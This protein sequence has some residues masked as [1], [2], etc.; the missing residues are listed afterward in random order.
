MDPIIEAALNAY[1]QGWSPI[2][3]VKGEKRPAHSDWQNTKYKSRDEIE[4]AFE[5]RNVGLLVGSAS[6]NLIDIDL[7]SDEAS[8]LASSFLPS[9]RMIHGRET[10][11]QSH[12]WYQCDDKVKYKKFTDPTDD[13]A[14]L[15]IRAKG[16]TVIPPSSHPSGEDYEW[17]EG[18][19]PPAQVPANTL[20]LDCHLLAAASLLAKHWPGEGSRHDASLALAGG[21]IAYSPDMPESRQTEDWVHD[22]CLLVMGAAGDEECIERADL[23]VPSTYKLH[24]KNKKVKGWKSLSKLISPKVLK[25]VRDWISYQ[26][27]NADLFEEEVR[28]SRTDMS[29]FISLDA[30]EVVEIVNGVIY[31]GKV[32]WLQGEP[33]TGKTIYALYLVKLC[34]DNG[35]RVMFVDEESGAAMTGKRLAALG[36]TPEDAERGFFYYQHTGIN[37]MDFEYRELFAEEVRQYHPDLIIFDSVADLMAQADLEENSNDHVN[38]FIKGFV[39]TVRRE[40]IATLFIDHLAKVSE[41]GQWARGAGSKKA[42]TDVAWTFSAIKS[43]NQNLMGDVSLKNAKDRFG[44]MPASHRYDIGG[45]GDGLIHITAKST[46]KEYASPSDKYVKKVVDYLKKHHSTDQNPIPTTELGKTIPGKTSYIRTAIKWCRDNTESL[47]IDFLKD[48]NTTLWYYSGDMELDFSLT[49]QEEK[50]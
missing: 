8:T 42:K 24:K 3:I 36:V 27:E 23:D 29:Q 21:L 17:W 10:S 43:F 6:N 25:V 20:V 9:T 48:G 47:P 16:Q 32:H 37:V 7:D 34:L 45:N 28:F 22:F 2:P 18:W 39:D 12:Y 46:V 30:P 13:S 40:N 33:G 11:P 14:I 49:E 15:E 5:G 38:A 41:A 26:D 50:E 1:D 44:Q 19:H 35:Y 31:Q 4:R